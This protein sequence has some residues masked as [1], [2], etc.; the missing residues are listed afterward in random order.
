MKVYEV[1]YKEHKV[2]YENN[3]KNK[4][5]SQ[6][7]SKSKFKSSIASLKSGNSFSKNSNFT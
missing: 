7:I 5:D 6:F 1:T 2:S 4:S 3:I